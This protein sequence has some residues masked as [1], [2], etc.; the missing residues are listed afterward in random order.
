MAVCPIMSSTCAQAECAWWSKADDKQAGR[1]SVA[2][3]P[4]KIDE[5]IK[6]LDGLNKRLDIAFSEINIDGER[7]IENYSDEMKENE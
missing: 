3:T 7:L 2:L 5:M 1:C 6:R 4:A